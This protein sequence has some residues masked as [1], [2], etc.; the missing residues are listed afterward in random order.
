M[1]GPRV[2]VEGQEAFEVAG[3]LAALAGPHLIV[4]EEGVVVVMKVIRMMM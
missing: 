4:S 1:R 2:W 3:R